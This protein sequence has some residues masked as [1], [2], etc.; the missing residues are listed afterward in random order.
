M[1]MNADFVVPVSSKSARTYR[2]VRVN[3]AENTDVLS[4]VPV[5][6]VAV[7]PATAVNVTLSSDSR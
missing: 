6:V 2:L 3:N 7:E 5:N 4:A 1:L